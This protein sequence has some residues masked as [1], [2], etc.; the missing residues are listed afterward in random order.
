[1]ITLRSPRLASL[2]LP[3]LLLSLAA[4][5]PLN[6]QE[7]TAPPELPTLPSPGG[8]SFHESNG[9]PDRDRGP[10]SSDSH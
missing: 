3:F 8:H 1:M 10:R 7:L 5:E 9:V 6:V 4:C 2:I